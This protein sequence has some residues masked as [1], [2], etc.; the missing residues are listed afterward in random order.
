[1]SYLK[2]S[3]WSVVC[4]L[5][6]GCYQQQGQRVNKYNSYSNP[7]EGCAGLRALQREVKQLSLQYY[8]AEQSVTAM[9]SQSDIIGSPG[10]WLYALGNE[11]EIYG[12]RDALARE[13]QLKANLYNTLVVTTPESQC[14]H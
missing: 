3:G 10:G 5:L 2:M 13:L 8:Q 6:A 7:Y 11:S 1:M 12:R 4:I 14:L 9:E